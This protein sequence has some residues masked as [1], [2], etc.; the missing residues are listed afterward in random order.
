MLDDFPSLDN[1]TEFK[2]KLVSN[3]KFSYSQVKFKR[4]A[5]I[6]KTRKFLQHLEEN[7]PKNGFSLKWSQKWNATFNLLKRMEAWKY[8]IN[9]IQAGSSWISNSEKSNKYYLSRF[10]QRQSNSTFSETFLSNGKTSSNPVDLESSVFKFY[11]N[12]YKSE[13]N[14]PDSTKFFSNLPR[15]ELT[16]SSLMDPITE[17]EL[18]KTILNLPKRK[19]PGPDGIP[20][21][22]YFKFRHAISPFLLYVLNLCL[23]GITSIPDSNSSFTITLFKKGEKHSLT[24]WRPISLSNTDAKFLSK[25]LATRL[26]GY[27][28]QV[29]SPSQFG[30]LPGRSIFDNIFQVTNVLQNTHAQ[31]AICFLDQ[32]KAYD[33]VDWNYLNT[34]LK[35]YGVNSRFVA[36]LTNTYSNTYFQVRS[37]NFCTNKIF[38]T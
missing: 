26:L 34:C 16:S 11:S 20:Y 1:W 6:C 2:T 8:K 10:S 38:P 17:E 33:R 13:D 4:T 30:F 3:S 15:C 31:G 25:I 28:N 9:Q 35:F 24:N 12:L 21:E 22:F 29:L 19:S 36:W 27:A 18:T 7:A 23:T 14:V 37:S 5:Q 32:E